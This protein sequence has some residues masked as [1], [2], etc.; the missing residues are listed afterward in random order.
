MPSYTWILSNPS[1]PSGPDVIAD[2]VGATE[3]AVVPGKSALRLPF[4]RGASR[5]ASVDGREYD[6][7]RISAVLLLDR[8]EL[9]W[10]PDEGTQI[11]RVAHRRTGA[12]TRELLEV[13]ASQAFERSLPDLRFVSL[14][15]RKEGNEQ[16]ALIHYQPRSAPIGQRASTSEAT[17]P[18][19]SNA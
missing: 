9:E 8:G 7:Q 15:L 6:E 1:T 16:H 3:I 12:V 2:G 17:V 14:D 5:F 18:L 11:R 13:Y 10:A 19:R 4:G